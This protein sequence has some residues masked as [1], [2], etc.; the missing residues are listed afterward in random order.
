MAHSENYYAVLGEEGAD[1]FTEDCDKWMASPTIQDD[2]KKLINESKRLVEDVRR[3]LDRTNKYMEERKTDRERFLARFLLAEVLAEIE[4]RVAPKESKY[5]CFL[6]DYFYD[7]CP[8][9]R[10]CPHYHEFRTPDETWDVSNDIMV[11][12]KACWEIRCGCR[13]MWIRKEEWDDY[14]RIMTQ[15]SPRAEHAIALKHFL[16]DLKKEGSENVALV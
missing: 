10:S 1:Q 16:D 14:E 7:D 2:T 13:D 5:E 8:Y 3:L 12:I 6:M 9:K 11:H 4:E 15:Y